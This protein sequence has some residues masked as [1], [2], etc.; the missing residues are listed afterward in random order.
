[1]EPC[2][3]RFNW[4]Q[5]NFVNTFSNSGS[6]DEWYLSSDWPTTTMQ[7]DRGIEPLVSAEICCKFHT[8]PHFLLSYAFLPFFGSVT[9]HFSPAATAAAASS[10]SSCTG[11]T[12]QL[13]TYLWFHVGDGRR[14]R[15][16]CCCWCWWWSWG[17]WCY[18]CWL[19][20]VL[21]PTDM[22]LW[23]SKDNLWCLWANLT[24]FRN[25]KK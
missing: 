15:C 6:I 10:D 8:F 18:Y 12:M 11:G 5:I 17:W 13:L 4:W 16:F 3:S 14:R 9:D 22:T 20:P 25:R 1:M 24:E 23:E 2:L 7:V 21:E 19:G